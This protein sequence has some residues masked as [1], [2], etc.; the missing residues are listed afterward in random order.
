MSNENFRRDLGNAFDELAGS[1]SH[2]LSDRVRSSLANTPEQRG[3]FWIAGVA[4]AVLA[5]IAVGVFFVTNP[6]NRP[7]A[8][9]G[10]GTASPSPTQSAAPSPSPS[11]SPSPAVSPASTYVCGVTMLNTFTPQPQPPVAFIDAIRTGTHTGYD[12]LTVEFNNGAPA[13]IDINPQSGT[14]FTLS[15]SGQKVA[16]AGSNG[17]LATIHGGDAHTSYTGLRDIKTGYSGLVEVRVVQDF[18]G[19]VQVAIGVSGPACYNYSLLSNPVRLVID[20]QV[21]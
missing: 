12:R 3:P 2:S 16:V 9:A 5:A 20:I 8:S 11:S 15:P 4:A 18:E 14:S 1:P 7:P 21:S 19:V 13:S 6:L 10:L 17:I